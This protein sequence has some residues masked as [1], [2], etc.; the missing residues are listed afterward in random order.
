[1]PADLPHLSL[2]KLSGLLEIEF[3]RRASRCWPSLQY[4]YLGYYLS[5]CHRMQYKECPIGFVGEMAS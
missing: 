2:G 5:T 3:V 1:M 4:Y